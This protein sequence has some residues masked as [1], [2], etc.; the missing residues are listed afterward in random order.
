MRPIQVFLVCCSSES[1]LLLSQ[2][3]TIL[4]DGRDRLSKGELNYGDSS[5]PLYSMYSK[6]AQQDDNRLAERC[7]RDTNGTMVFVS[8]HVKL[9]RQYVSTGKYRRVYL[10]P[11]SVHC[12]RSQCK[13]SSQISNVPLRSILRTYSRFSAIRTH[14]KSSPLILC[15]HRL[16]S[17]RLDMLSG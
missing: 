3:M 14:L 9:L 12:S 6:I 10:P 1:L 16:C 7:Q 11:P 8:P 4:A 5:W 17:R 15:P 13:T 2:R